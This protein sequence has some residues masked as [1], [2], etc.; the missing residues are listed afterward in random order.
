MVERAAAV[1]ARPGLAV[2]TAQN[3]V[4]GIGLA[5]L[6]NLLWTLGDT[7]AKWAIPVA[8]VGGAMLWRGAFGAVVAFQVFGVLAAFNGWWALGW[9]TGIVQ[10][11]R[12]VVAWSGWPDPIALA[13]LL[14]PVVPLAL[15]ARAVVLAPETARAEGDQS[16]T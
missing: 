15:L 13:L 10:P 3:T 14:L 1:A 8:G 12:A 7:A 2:E 4:L 5:V 9:S 16:L 6:C 11:V